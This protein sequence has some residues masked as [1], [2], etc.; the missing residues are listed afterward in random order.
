MQ[1]HSKEDVMNVFIHD[2]FLLQ[3]HSDLMQDAILF[4]NK[5]EDSVGMTNK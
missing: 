1:I 4:E 3:K 2:I 5:W